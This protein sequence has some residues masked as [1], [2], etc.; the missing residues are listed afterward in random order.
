M[1]STTLLQSAPRI[2]LFANSVPPSRFWYGSYKFTFHHQLI[3]FEL[4]LKIECTLFLHVVSS[5]CLWELVFLTKNIAANEEDTVFFLPRIFSYTE[6]S[7]D[8]GSLLWHTKCAWERVQIPS[9]KVKNED[10]K[11]SYQGFSAVVRNVSSSQTV[12]SR[13]VNTVLFQHPFSQQPFKIIM[14]KKI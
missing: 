14:R 10:E 5:H 12:L 1:K 3:C 9:G 8:I 11:L 2:F 4:I 13:S 6:W 7:F